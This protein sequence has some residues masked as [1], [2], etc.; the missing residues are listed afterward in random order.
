[1]PSPQRGLHLLRP[2]QIPEQPELGELRI[3]EYPLEAAAVR[4]GTDI[5]MHIEQVEAREL[6]IGTVDLCQL[7][8][9]RVLEHQENIDPSL[10]RN[11]VPEVLE[12]AKEE[13]Q[14]VGMNVVLPI[15][16]RELL[17]QGGAQ[18]RVQRHDFLQLSQAG[19]GHIPVPALAGTRIEWSFSDK[20]WLHPVAL[21]G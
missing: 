17:R 13:H 1:M 4:Q 10:S 9:R 2:A 18:H 12:R 7:A 14:V 15:R 5:S 3:R 19:P 6:E 20:Q 16:R 8:C 21:R 11:P